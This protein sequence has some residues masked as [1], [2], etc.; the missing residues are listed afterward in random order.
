MLW[1]IADSW[2]AIV[3]ALALLAAL[4]GTVWW[5]TRNKRYLVGTV[6]ALALMPIVWIVSLLV[7][8]D[9]MQLETNVAE[10]RDAV[11]AGNYNQALK[12]FDDTVTI[13]AT[14]GLGGAVL[15]QP[16]TK[17]KILAMANRSK[18]AYQVKQITTGRVYIDELSRP[19][20]KIRFL[21][22]DADDFTKRGWCT[23]DC[24]WKGGKWVVTTMT[25]VAVIGG[26]TMPVLLPVN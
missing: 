8:T 6:A 22:A 1:W 19:R 3:M 4:L 24:Q 10:I 17:D 18:D 2:L 26:R 20:A 14:M 5:H 25:V 7:V 16:L 21:V 13:T 23:M 15:T 12:Y 9:S 11:N